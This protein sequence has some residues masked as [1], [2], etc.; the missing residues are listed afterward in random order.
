MIQNNVS[1]AFA[2]RAV[3]AEPGTRL[4]GMVVAAAAS[5]L[6]FVAS[7]Q[8]QAAPILSG[9][10]DQIVTVDPAIDCAGCTASQ[11]DVLER[12]VGMMLREMHNTAVDS[13]VCVAEASLTKDLAILTFEAYRSGAI[14]ENR[15]RDGLRYKGRFAGRLTMATIDTML[16]AY[17]EAIEKRLG[18]EI[19]PGSFEALQ[20]DIYASAQLSR[21][22]A[23]MAWGDWQSA[24]LPALEDPSGG[25]NSA[26]DTVLGLDWPGRGIYNE[27]LIYSR[28]DA[29][30]REAELARITHLQDDFLI[31]T[32]EGDRDQLEASYR[33]AMSADP[34][35]VMGAG[36]ATQAATGF[37]RHALELTQGISFIALPTTKGDIWVD[38]DGN[39]YEIHETVNVVDKMPSLNFSWGVPG[40]VRWPTTPPS[41]GGG[42]GSGGSDGDGNT[43]LPVP[44]PPVIELPETPQEWGC[45]PEIENCDGIPNCTFNGN[46][47]GSPHGVECTR[48][49]DLC[50]GLEQLLC[51]APASLDAIGIEVPDNIEVFG[52]GI[53]I[54]RCRF[55]R[56]VCAA[57]GL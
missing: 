10:V 56:V 55:I 6:F 49:T 21:I 30:W 14:S 25:F 41:G 28:V 7:G 13:Q 37:R 9:D 43:T 12:G 40:N 51:D 35:T 44:S 18:I 47:T 22:F 52:T 20:T 54:D 31:G 32:I 38:G 57:V 15:W 5:L 4:R 23:K 3:T 53:K 33:A 8:T 34:W 11:L 45:N 48:I 42:V 46:F 19:P 29:H 39:I 16:L 27:I 17:R 50:L 1:I 24:W 2:Q 26:V 36:C